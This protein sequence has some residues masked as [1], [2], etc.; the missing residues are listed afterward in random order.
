[1]LADKDS[2]FDPNK[3]EKGGV[4]KFYYFE[5]MYGTLIERYIENF[6]LESMYIL[7]TEMLKKD[8]NKEI[9]KCFDFLQLPRLNKI[10]QKQENMTLG[11]Q[12]NG[13]P[14]LLKKVSFILPNKYFGAI[15]DKC[16]EK[17]FYS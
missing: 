14:S 7:T 12:C 10:M 17:I 16:S 2:S 15:K 9:N 4:Y 6:G 11:E 1:M 13:T 5:S 8:F 3:P